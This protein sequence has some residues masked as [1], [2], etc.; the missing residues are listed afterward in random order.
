MATTVP[1]I[2]HWKSYLGWP[3]PGFREILREIWRPFLSGAKC[4][5]YGPFQR[6]TAPVVGNGGALWV[7]YEIARASWDFI[8]NFNFI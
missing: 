5:K 3:K 7:R 8:G 6:S 2:A 4:A 1:S